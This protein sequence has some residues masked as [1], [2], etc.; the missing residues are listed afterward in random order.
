LG[1]GGSGI[2]VQN[3]A[4]AEKGERVSSV[5]GQKRRSRKIPPFES[6]R[7]RGGIEKRKNKGKS[8]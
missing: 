5:G 7:E 8:L 3:T 6:S 1:G 4:M 2:Y